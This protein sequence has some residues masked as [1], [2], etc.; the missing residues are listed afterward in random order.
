MSDQNGNGS[1][2]AAQNQNQGQDQ[3]GNAP[4]HKSENMIPKSRFDEVN[5][6]RKDAE[7]SLQSVVAE[8]KD[9]IPEEYRD[10]VP[11]LPATE[12]IKWIR[13]AQKSGLFSPK[14]PSNSPD[15]KRPGG[16]GGDAALT[17]YEKF[18]KDQSQEV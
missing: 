11:S 6:K 7:E 10:L 3:P 18:I 4:D 1:D 5:Q 16:K 14:G 9:D 13:T 2:N 8:M 12:Q 17:D 15:S